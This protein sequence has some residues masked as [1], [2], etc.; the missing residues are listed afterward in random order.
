M[1]DGTDEVR[2]AEGVVHHYRQAVLVSNLSDG[3]NI[4]NVAVGV[5]QSLQIDSPGVLLNGSFHLAEVMGIH[6]GSLHAELGESVGQQV[7]SAAIDGLLSYDMTA[8]S[9]QRLNGVGD[10]CCPGS[11]CQCCAAP[12]Q[13]GNALLQHILGRIG[14]PAVN[15]ACI[16]Q[17]KAVSC[18]LAV[19]ENIGSGLIN[20]DC[21]CIR[22]R[23]RLLLSHM[24]LQG[25]KFVLAHSK[26]PFHSAKKAPKAPPAKGSCFWSLQFF[27]SAH[28]KL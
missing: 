12:F 20:R 16:S 14:K 15:V 5:A 19:A 25:F 3:V 8:V 24:K 10:G 11:Y 1:L 4:G 6:E 26:I 7:V 27:W 28:L 13:S 18:V 2:G 23:I 21:P 22:S 9:G 17:A